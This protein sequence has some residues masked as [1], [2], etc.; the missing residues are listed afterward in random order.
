MLDSKDVAKDMTAIIKKFQARSLS[1]EDFPDKEAPSQ[2][3]IT[4]PK[5]L[6]RLKRL[7]ARAAAVNSL[8]NDG[9]NIKPSEVSTGLSNELVSSFVDKQ[10]KIVVSSQISIEDGYVKALKS[11]KDKE[12]LQGEQ[13]LILR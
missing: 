1:L 11:S 7:R 3:L 6:E 9:L 8:S 10:P 13:Q 2:K 12:S 4:P 5:S